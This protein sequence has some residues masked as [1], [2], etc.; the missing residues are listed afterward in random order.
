MD[1]EGEDRGAR[2]KTDLRDVTHDSIF[3]LA[4][5]TLGGRLR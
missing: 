3:L 1:E 4:P 2:D 5:P